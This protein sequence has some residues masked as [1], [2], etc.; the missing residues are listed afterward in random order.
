MRNQIMNAATLLGAALDFTAGIDSPIR[1]EKV[2]GKK[3]LSKK[4]QKARAK[5]KFAKQW[6][7]K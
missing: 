3:N 7:K 6:K 4:T 1:G 2:K 5:K